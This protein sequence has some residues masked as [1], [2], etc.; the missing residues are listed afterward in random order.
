MTV[1]CPFENRNWIFGKIRKINLIDRKYLMIGSSHFLFQV[2][3]L[4]PEEVDR[5]ELYR[6]LKGASRLYR[7]L[8]KPRVEHWELS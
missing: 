5:W 1:L 3:E 6:E 7:H 8:R 4:Q 2:E